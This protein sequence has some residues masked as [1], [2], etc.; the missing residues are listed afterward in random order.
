MATP[1]PGRRQLFV[2]WHLDAADV[3]VALGAV[4]AMQR[5]LRAAKPTLSTGLY[6]RSDLAGDKAT[7]M[8][9]Y[10]CP[11]DGV[12]AALQQHIETVAAVALQPWQRGARH[13]EV[14]DA[15]DD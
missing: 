12:D 10:A 4:Q 3:S 11:G 9:T 5:Q 15:C 6:R 7:L 8:E 14:F 13:V 1:R 2:Y